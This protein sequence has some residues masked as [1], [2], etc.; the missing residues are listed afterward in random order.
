MNLPKLAVRYRAIVLALV[1]LLMLWG[2]NSFLTMPRREDPAYTVRTCAIVTA[3]PGVSAVD[4]EE[5]V[6]A[7]LEKAVDSID[8]VDVVRSST[9][10]GLSTIYVD[11]EEWVSAAAIDNVWDKVRANVAKVKMPER[12]VIPIVQDDFGDTSILLFTVF[13]KPLDGQP[14]IEPRNRYS[15]RELDVITQ[16]IS[17][18]MRMIPGVA[19]CS[20]FGV[21]QEVISIETDMG[22]WSQLALTT[23]QLQRLVDARNVL[24]AGGS[25]D[26][27]VG[28]FTIKPSGEFDSVEELKSVI[29]DLAQDRASGR[30]PAEVRMEASPVYLDD[31]GLSIVREYES[32]KK[33]ICRYTD[34]HRSAPAVI[35][36][37]T[38]KNGS[39]IIDVCHMAQER[40]EEMQSRDLILPPDIQ[41]EPISD[42]S[43][44]VEAKISGVVVNVIEAV[45]IVILVVYLVVGFRSAAVMAANIPIV[46]IISIGMI[47]LFGV[48][49][50]QISLASIIIA[51]GLLVD[52]AVQVCDQC[53]TNQIRGLPPEEA[54]VTGAN[55]VGLAM[56]GGTATTVAAFLPMLFGLVGTKRE[57]IY[58]LPVTLSVTLALSWVL[59]MTFCTLL[60]ARFIRAPRDPDRPSAPLPWLF[61][62]LQRGLRRKK[63]SPDTGPQSDIVETLFRVVAGA[64]VRYKFITFGVSVLLLVGAIRLPIGSEFFPKDLRDQFAVEVWL[65]ENVSIEQTDIAARQVERLL[66]KL[67]PLVDADGNPVKDVDG[68]VVQRI[69]SMRTLVGGGGARWYM[70]R[71]PEAAKPNYAEILIRT[72]DANFTSQLAADV[73]RVSV[74]IEAQKQLGLEAANQLAGMRV[75]PREL[76]LGPGVAS[77]IGFRIIGTG[78]EDPGF[79]SIQS[80]HTIADRLKALL[81]K[82]PGTWDTHDTWG[83]AGYQLL[84]HVDPDKANLAGVSNSS[85]AQTLNAYFSGHKLTTYREGSHELPVYLRLP[86][87]DDSPDASVTTTMLRNAMSLDDLN[88]AFVEGRFGKVPLSSIATVEQRWEPTKVDRRAL[89]RMIEVNSRVRDGVRA[90]DVVDALWA[91]DGMRELLASLPG[92]FRI[93]IGGDKEQSIESSQQMSMCLVMSLLLIVLCLVFQYNGWAKP[94]LILA[95]L[96]LAL[97]GA[98]PGLYIT[99]N[100]LGFM[101]QLGILA[102][103]GIVLNTGIIFM[104]FADQLILAAVVKSDGSGP[105]MGLTPSQFRKCL[106]DAGLARLLPIFLT[107]ATTVGGL[108]PLALAGGPLWEGMAWCMIFGLLIATL[109]TLLV[110]PAMYAILVETFKL[111]PVRLD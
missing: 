80:M 104:E 64:S 34:P 9:T 105:I 94:V 99:G 87:Q 66:Q 110:I 33:S 8:E 4:V 45:L 61:D 89:N 51:L 84:V 35:V 90:N 73:G 16:K 65:P 79:A 82:Q 68:K 93:E 2:T 22:N 17:D 77:P 67:S 108:L 62:R 10:V 47:T 3:W 13:Q 20:R 101:S 32:P 95:T 31:L 48:Q 96:P 56:L 111:Q 88:T 28:R 78:F 72:T 11:A 27:D 71:N 109:L 81:R 21:Q 29:V 40:V 36:A 42:Q 6:T 107:T 44:N 92:G 76:W 55:Q 100:P 26:T 18:E 25:L 15:P 7:K 98:L 1:A 30:S 43:V 53:R 85:V 102:L 19:K 46:V 57:Y 58:S 103:F 83:A 60:A 75:I 50:E 63:K 24:A 14:E 70:G 37:M 106:V 69:R 39:S 54:A 38:M 59:A 97:I 74:D 91:S 41:V 12:G 49:L 23:N 86:T 5:L 52:N